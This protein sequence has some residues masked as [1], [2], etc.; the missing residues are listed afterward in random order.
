MTNTGPIFY[1]SNYGGSF[2]QA[3]ATPTIQNYWT[4]AM[5]SNG[6]YQLAGTVEYSFFTDYLPNGKCQSLYFLPLSSD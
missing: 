1:S 5:S 6:Q 2:T 3:T 4:V